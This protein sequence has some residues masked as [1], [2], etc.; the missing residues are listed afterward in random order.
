MGLTWP[1][2]TFLRSKFRGLAKRGFRITV[3]SGC[4]LDPHVDIENLR[5]VR[6]PGDEGYSPTLTRGLVLGGARTLFT[7]PH[8]FVRMVRVA[9]RTVG[10]RQSWR[11][12]IAAVRDFT[13]MLA[14]FMPLA[15]L[16]ADVVHFE[17]D[18]A[19][20]AF[21]PL[22]DVWRCPMVMSLHGELHISAHAPGRQR[23]MEGLPAA[24]EDASAVHCVSE[25]LREE[26]ALHGLPPG[27]GVLIRSAVDVDHFRPVGGPAGDEF[28]IVVVAWLRWLKGIEYA[29]SALRLLVDAG[30][31]ARLDVFGGDPLPPLG[32]PSDRQRVLH[33]A[34]D[35]GV[36][37]RVRLHGH[38]AH[39][40]LAAE[41]QTAHA[42]LHPSL[43]EGIPTVILEAMACG[44]P[45]VA[46][47]CGGVAEAVTDGVE[48]FVVEPRDA[49][50][51]AA[52]LE[53]LW[54]EPELRRRMGDAGRAR[55]EAEFSL[56]DQVAAYAALYESVLS[57]RAVSQPVP[58]REP[59]EVAPGFAQRR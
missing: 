54:R 5:V 8:R 32:E 55:V 49:P 47:D 4:V 13:R 50:G 25:A 7:A 11:T 52:A 56:E 18:S 19:A 15:H 12:P 58:E 43:S 33:A 20:V 10:A 2:E 40:Q 9:L 31:P 35:L 24:F 37:E 30:V 36:A 51:L 27:K 34:A 16:K 46:T 6:F 22:L 48:G 1:S 23:V 28:R 29:V 21:R 17:W 3:A 53:R 39:D 44:V 59:R 45:V 38:V 57:P 42:M 26:A 14:I 41:L